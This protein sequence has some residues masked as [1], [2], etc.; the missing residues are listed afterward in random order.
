MAW[1][2]RGNVWWLALGEAA[3]GLSLRL[4]LK[5]WSGVVLGRRREDVLRVV[6]TKMRDRRTVAVRSFLKRMK[7]KSVIY[8]S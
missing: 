7:L 5:Q 6:L 3:P 1:V 2:G 4:W 8:S